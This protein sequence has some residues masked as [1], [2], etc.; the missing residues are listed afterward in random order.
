MNTYF[1]VATQVLL[2]VGLEEAKASKGWE[3]IKQRAKSLLFYIMLDYDWIECSY[4]Y[5]TYSG[6][7][8]QFWKV[9]NLLLNPRSYKLA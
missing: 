6:R 1:T 2:R 4:F 7:F 5:V 9:C 8:G 3:A